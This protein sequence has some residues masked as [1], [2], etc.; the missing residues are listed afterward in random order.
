M[1]GNL[2]KEAVFPFTKFP[3]IDVLLGPEMKSTGEVMGIADDFGAAF[4]KSQHGAGSFLPM[5][6]RGFISVKDKDKPATVPLAP[7]FLEVGFTIPAP[8]GT[9][10]YP[11]GRGG[12]V[13]PGDKVQE[14]RPA[15][16]EHIK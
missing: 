16:V 8:R 15:C 14:G 10:A 12:M 3:N 6:G 1:L 13:G 2:V 9:A 5:Q 7:R 4:L 11:A